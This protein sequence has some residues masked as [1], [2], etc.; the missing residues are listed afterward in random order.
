MV[1]KYLAVITDAYDEV[2]GEAIPFVFDFRLGWRPY[3]EIIDFV[4]DFFA[5]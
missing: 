4:R 5:L 3:A 2:A 1:N